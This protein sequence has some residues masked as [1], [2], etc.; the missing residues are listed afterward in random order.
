MS[1]SLLQTNKAKKSLFCTAIR[2]AKDA[3]DSD[4]HR[5]DCVFVVQVCYSSVTTVKRY[6]SLE[7]EVVRRLRKERSAQVVHLVNRLPP[8]LSSVHP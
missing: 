7:S 8:G 4:A 3:L 5:P 1:C 2:E 6:H